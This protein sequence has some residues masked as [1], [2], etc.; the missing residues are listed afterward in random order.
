VLPGC[1]ANKICSLVCGI[2]FL[3]PFNASNAF[4]Y[5]P[6]RQLATALAVESAQRRNSPP[7]MVH[8]QESA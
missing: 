6:A 4:A 3:P 8:K 7:C 2:V 5:S 1:F